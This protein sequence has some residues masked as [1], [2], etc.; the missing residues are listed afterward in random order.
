MFK[1]K[2]YILVPKDFGF[3]LKKLWQKADYTDFLGIF[4]LVIYALVFGWFFSVSIE[5][6]FFFG[7]IIAVIYW[8]MDSRV[9]I[10]L[11]LVCLVLTPL[12]LFLFE[13][14]FLFQGEIWAEKLAVWAY[15]F[16]VIGVVKQMFELKSERVT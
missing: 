5:P 10:A 12:C 11:A 3:F 8:R 6:L 2:D 14:N 4:L 13:K 7:F 15:F 9:S 1:I 16:L